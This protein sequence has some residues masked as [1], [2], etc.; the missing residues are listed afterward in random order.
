MSLFFGRKKTTQQQQQ[1]QVSNTIGTP[2]ESTPT[3]GVRLK[4]AEESLDRH[5]V[6]LKK[7]KGIDLSS[8]RARVF[9]VIDRSGSMYDLYNDGSVQDVLT[10]LLPLA[11]RFD[12]NGE[13]E[14]YV[15]NNDV[16]QMPSMTLN[17]YQTYVKRQ[18]LDRRYGPSGGTSYAPVIQQT[19][20]DYD[21]GSPYPAFGIFITDGENSDQSCTDAAIRKSSKY[22]IFYQ[23]VGIGNER[24]YYLQKLDDLDGRKVDNTAF[25]K[26]KDFAAL[27]DDQLYDKLLEQYPSWLNAMHIQ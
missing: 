17:N 10:R 8:H 27:T 2:V 20:H 3:H 18:I 23:F 14:V 5:I 25:V 22:R 11:L 12:D 16:N 6:R 1:Q 15:F 9:V 4:K 24:F 26:V 19:I 13:L 21:D 7:E